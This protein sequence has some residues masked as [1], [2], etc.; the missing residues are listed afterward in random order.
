MFAGRSQ[1]GLQVRDRTSTRLVGPFIVGTTLKGQPLYAYSFTEVVV[2]DW[3]GRSGDWQ[4]GKLP[5][6]KSGNLIL[7]KGAV[8]AED[9]HLQAWPCAMSGDGYEDAG[10]A[11]DSWEAIV[12]SQPTGDSITIVIDLAVRGVGTRFNRLAYSWTAHVTALPA[13]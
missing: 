9:I 8:R 3:P 5:I 6:P 4:R 10:W 12:E 2:C 11:L 7:P 1:Q 13:R